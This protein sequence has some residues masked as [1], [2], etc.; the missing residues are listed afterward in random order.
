V[1]NERFSLYDS[2][3]TMLTHSSNDMAYAN[4]TS[5]YTGKRSKFFVLMNIKAKKIGMKKAYFESESGLDF[6]AGKSTASASSE[7]VIVLLKYFYK[8]YPNL[9]ARTVKNNTISSNLK[10][11]YLY[12]TNILLSEYNNFRLSKTGLEDSSGGNLATV[13]KID[14]ENYLAISVLNSTKK[15]RFLIRER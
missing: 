6:P 1:L 15:G 7:D 8:N 13:Y 10:K 3:V 9:S 5:G 2:I 11:H 12:N 14:N 4:S